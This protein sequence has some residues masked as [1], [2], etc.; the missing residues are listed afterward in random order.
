MTLDP[1]CKPW[2]K[3]HFCS[4]LI[5]NIFCISSL[6]VIYLFL[7]F[8]HSNLQIIFHYFFNKNTVLRLFYCVASKGEFL[9]FFDPF[10][11]PPWIPLLSHVLW[12][13]GRSGFISSLDRTSFSW[14]QYS[15]DFAG[16]QYPKYTK[17]TTFVCKNYRNC[18]KCSKKGL[19]VCENVLYWIRCDAA[20]RHKNA[21]PHTREG[22][23]PYA[24]FLRFFWMR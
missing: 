12:D 15:I 19:Q 11:D 10:L 23:F 6:S 5:S 21:L 18:F 7:R 2:I 4:L 24:F 1:G 3:G 22:V 16:L 14:L 8:T 9:T 13:L 17:F 20:I